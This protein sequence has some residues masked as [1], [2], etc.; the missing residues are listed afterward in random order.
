METL[1]FVDSKSLSEELLRKLVLIDNSV[2]ADF[3]PEWKPTEIDHAERL[4]YFQELSDTDFFKTV[5]LGAE[6]VG[7]HVIRRGQG[8]MKNIG[9]ISTLW[10]HPDH[11]GKGIAR[12]L[13]AMGVEWARAQK[14]D[15]LQT[16]SHSTNQR[17]IE[18]NLKAGF[19]PH[20]ITMRMKL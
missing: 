14:L 17:M 9:F 12:K 11:R 3:D 2:P 6:I 15:Y 10:V 16:S 8:A 5:L 20:A 4:K 13:K 7:F 18:M 19:K 1:E